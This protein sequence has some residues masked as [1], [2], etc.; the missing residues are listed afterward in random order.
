MDTFH[1]FQIVV[2]E[3][4]GVWALDNAWARVMAG[5]RGT[6]LTEGSAA[7]VERR[8]AAGGMFGAGE[9]IVC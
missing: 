5:G 4:E 9:A 8:E 7:A 2:A 3:L 6:A 1:A